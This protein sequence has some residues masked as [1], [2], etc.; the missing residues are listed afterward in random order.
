MTPPSEYPNTRT[1]DSGQYCIGIGGCGINL[2]DTILLRQEM[3][4]SGSGSPAGRW[5]QIL[6][7]EA[8]LNANRYELAN[9]RHFSE[10]KTGEAT[11]PATAYVFDPYGEGAGYDWQRGRKLLRNH[12]DSADSWND[13]WGDD[14]RL[15]SLTDAQS[16]WLLH[17]AHGGTGAGA[18][19]E[20][21]RALRDRME[22]TSDG[23]HDATPILSFPVFGYRH[24]GTDQQELAGLIGLARLS[25][26]TDAILPLANDHIDRSE[27]GCEVDGIED[28]IP[29]L[30]ERNAT[31][32]Q[33]LELLGGAVAS[34]PGAGRGDTIRAQDICRP[35]TQHHPE[36]EGS[37]PLVLAPAAAK[38]ASEDGWER[39]TLE[40]LLERLKMDTLMSFE[41]STANGGVFVFCCPTDDIDGLDRVIQ[42]EGRHALRDRLEFEGDHRS[43]HVYQTS[44]EGLD[45][46]YLLG[47]FRN[48]AIPR[49][50]GLIDRIHEIEGTELDSVI[51]DD[52]E[53]YLDRIETIVR[54]GS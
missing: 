37:P 44:F 43:L 19:P 10:R 27:I 23:V 54:P 52:A 5:D 34:E 22:Q 11:E 2:V 51:G 24:E 47:L 25:S 18:T 9:S 21:A 45:S 50:D 1:A 15:S 48:P 13:G 14:L 12:I 26:Q 16:I 35:V 20:F 29:P 46:V 33:F 40:V 39:T 8:M 49:F 36:T 6:A 32:V 3:D 38:S 31:I 28:W 17:S 41:P 53:R 7:G 4:G 42:Q 30:E